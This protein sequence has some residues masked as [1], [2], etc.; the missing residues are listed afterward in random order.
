M[1]LHLHGSV[2][3]GPVLQCARGTRPYQLILTA[4]GYITRSSN[5]RGSKI[6]DALASSVVSLGGLDRIPSLPTKRH[7]SG[8]STAITLPQLSSSLHH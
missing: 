4:Q 2:L 7:M 3:H 8:Y 6:A 5:I 1:Y